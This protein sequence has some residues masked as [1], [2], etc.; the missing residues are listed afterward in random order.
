MERLN[1]KFFLSLLFSATLV[2]SLVLGVLFLEGGDDP[3]PSLSQFETNS[4]EHSL[5]FNGSRAWD[6]LVQQVELGFRYPGSSEIQQARILYVKTLL[7]LGWVVEFH[8]F[9]HLG[10]DSVN[11]LAFPENGSREGVVLF[12]AH[13]DT[14]WHADR[15]PVLSNQTQP[16]LG[17]NDGAS[18]V[19]ILLE[20]AHVYSNSSGVALLFIDAEDQGG[21]DGWRYIHGSRQFVDE[22]VLGQFFPNGKADISAFILFDMIGDWD[23]NIHKEGNSDP[24]LMDEIWTVAHELGYGDAFPLSQKYTM[25]D[26]HVPFV[27]AGIPAVDLIDFDYVDENGWNLHHTTRDVLE[28]VAEDSLWKVGQTTELWFQNRSR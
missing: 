14:R 1:S 5:T 10:I 7:S 15:D 22:A 27:E 25:V 20:L 9:T 13:Y 17:A 3:T 6:Y 11:I 4:Q 12:G 24:T 26:D 28:Y 23:L 21:I 2:L 19:A 8:N 16:V 18:G